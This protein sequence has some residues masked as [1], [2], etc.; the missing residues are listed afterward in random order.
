MLL[1]DCDIFIGFL[2]VVDLGVG[3]IFFIFILHFSNFLLFKVLLDINAKLLFIVTLIFFFIL[4]FLYV[5]ALP[6]DIN[7][8][9][10]L[11]KT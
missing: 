10:T 6:T 5:F 3:L 7:F 1:D 2:W 9:Y 4:I 8:N 11:M